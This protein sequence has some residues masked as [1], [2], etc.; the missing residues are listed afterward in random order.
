M[1]AAGMLFGVVILMILFG[2]FALSKL[3][4]ATQDLYESTALTRAL[5]LD[6]QQ[7]KI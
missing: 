2:A 4:L 5:Y 3:G 1:R 7:N 6:V